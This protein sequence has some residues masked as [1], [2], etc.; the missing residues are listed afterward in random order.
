M[1]SWVV[2]P[3]LGLEEQVEADNWDKGK[4]IKQPKAKAPIEDVV[5][6]QVKPYKLGARGLLPPRHRYQGSGSRADQNVAE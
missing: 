5:L 4:N 2:T 1:K 6:S 3:G